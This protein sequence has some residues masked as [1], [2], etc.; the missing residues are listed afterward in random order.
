MNSGRIICGA[1]GLA[2]A[3][4]FGAYIGNV[5]PKETMAVAFISNVMQ[6][7]LLPYLPSE[8]RNSR[9][10]ALLFPFMVAEGS[11]RFGSGITG[12]DYV[13]A[14]ACGITSL[15]AVCL[16]ALMV[17]RIRAAVM[18]LFIGPPLSFHARA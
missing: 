18:P 14:Q 9:A 15:T 7:I 11:A 12:M 17:P 1:S 3:M 4:G 5:P 16:A 8:Y 13:W 10:V 6:A 2:A